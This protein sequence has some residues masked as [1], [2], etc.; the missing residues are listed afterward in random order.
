V[1]ACATLSSPGD[2]SRTKGERGGSFP[3]AIIA[4]SLIRRSGAREAMVSNNLP[5]RM[6]WQENICKAFMACL[7]TSGARRCWRPLILVAR[8]NKIFLA[9]L[10]L[11]KNLQWCSC[12]ASQSPK[13]NFTI[14]SCSLTEPFINISSILSETKRRIFSLFFPLCLKKPPGRLSQV[15]QRVEANK[16]VRGIQ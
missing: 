10:L 12:Q 13:K 16:G 15:S 7:L 1:P 11:N 9:N 5:A 14:S 4:S 2:T 6:D 3:R 8:S